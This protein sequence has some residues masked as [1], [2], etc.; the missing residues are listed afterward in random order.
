[1]IFLD[2]TPKTQTMKAKTN[3]WNYINPK[4]FC[5]AKETNNKMKRQPMEWEKIF[6][7]HISDKG[8][9]LNYISSIAKHPIKNNTIKNGQGN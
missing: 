7:H 1:M 5:T 8:L 2:L 4:S 3:K 9:I 6:A